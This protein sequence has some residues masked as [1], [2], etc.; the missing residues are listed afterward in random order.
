MASRCIGLCPAGQYACGGGCVG[1]TDPA[2]CGADCTLCP[3]PVHGSALCAAGACGATCEAG[4]ALL[5]STCLEVDEC[6]SGNGGCDPL[7]L[8][9]NTP[10]WRSCGPCPAGYFGNGEVGCTGG[11]GHPCSTAADCASGYCDRATTCAALPGPPQSLSARAGTGA[12]LDILLIW[13]AP[14][15]DGG[16][17]VTGYLVERATASMGPFAALATVHGTSFDNT[18]V[19]ANTTYYYRVFAINV[20]GTGAAATADATSLADSVGAFVTLTGVV[21]SAAGTPLAEVLVSA[22]SATEGG[23]ATTTDAE[24]RYSALVPRGQVTLSVGAG[25][26]GRRSAQLP[27][28]FLFEGSINV[29]SDRALDVTLPAAHSVTFRAHD[30]GGAPIIGAGLYGVSQSSATPTTLWPGGPS[31]GV[32]QDGP[33]STALPTDATGSA[34]F[35]AFQTRALSTVYLDYVDVDGVVFRATTTALSVSADLVVPVVLDLAVAT[36]TLTI[37]TAAGVPVAGLLVATE[38]TVGY[39]PTA[40]TDSAG[41]ATLHQPRGAA[42]LS[43]AAGSANTDAVHLPQWFVATGAIDAGADATLSVALPVAYSVTIHVTDTAATPLAGAHV[44]G[45]SQTLVSSA[46]LWSGGSRFTL[47]QDA[48][49]TAHYTNASG[50]A[51]FW[52][53]AA[54]EIGTVYTDYEDAAHTAFRATTTLAVSR[55]VTVPVVIDVTRNALT[56]TITDALGAPVSGLYVEAVG[57]AGAADAGSTDSGGHVTL[58][59]Q[60]GTATLVI[61]AGSVDGD[62]AHLP[63]W[64]ALRGAVD[65]AADLALALTLP[66]AYRVS[67][68]VTKLSGAALPG[69]RV[70]DVSQTPASPASLWSGGPTFTASQDP[71][72]VAHLT[73]ASGDTA[74]W[75]FASTDIGTIYLDYVDATSTLYRDT[76]A[77]A[78]AGDTAIDASLPV[79]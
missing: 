63:S 38:S 5:G 66:I 64:F 46:A 9:T 37:T 65:V 43:I 21:R 47:M 52:A 74:F 77:L 76:R 34:T 27:S 72:G 54:P 56:L 20:A 57:A 70:Y 51:T 36:L 68:R 7:T 33:G 14:A 49:G 39:S 42:T 32:L 3:T 15:T 26:I 59:V 58:H 48:A 18:D 62:A 30:T 69:A 11:V 71:A 2:A 6:A 10:G 73:N 50:D 61:A 67:A 1:A 31:F 24:G 53:F 12:T 79:P 35:Y 60:S 29:Q 8:C 22:Q 75:A 16:T 25:D 55:D 28:W 45:V 78:V 17:S 23:T 44:Y 41:R 4:F 13:A 40:N 19:S